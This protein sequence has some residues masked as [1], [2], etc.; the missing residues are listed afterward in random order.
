MRTHRADRVADHEPSFANRFSIALFRLRD[1]G[2]DERNHSRRG[3]RIQNFVADKFQPIAH[4][5]L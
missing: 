1:G 4:H 3:E 5:R 2:G